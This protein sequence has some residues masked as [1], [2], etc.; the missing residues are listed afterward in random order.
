MHKKVD[1]TIIIFYCKNISYTYF[2]FI[3]RF[4][5]IGKAMVVSEFIIWF[6]FM[7]CLSVSNSAFNPKRYL[8]PR[9]IIPLAQEFFT[10]NDSLFSFG[11]KNFIKKIKYP[12]KC[13][14][15]NFRK[16]FN[17][18]TFFFYM[19][20]IKPMVTIISKSLI[21]HSSIISNL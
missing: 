5:C 17:N 12:R 10:L 2:I 16:K 13:I 8:S 7:K 4:Q 3:S 9:K 1:E 6:V 11:W 18:Q 19:P 14:I 15:C 20:I 21:C